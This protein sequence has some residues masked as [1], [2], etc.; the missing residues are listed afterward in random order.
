M[1][2]ITL[3]EESFNSDTN[4]FVIAGSLNVTLEHSLVSLSKWEALWKKPFL[5]KN[6]NT[7]EEILSYLECMVVGNVPDK[8]WIS[9]LTTE[10]VVKIKA[11]IEDDQ[12]ATTF[13]NKGSSQ[14]RVTETITSEL[15][16]YWMISQGI[17]FTC[18]TWHLQRLITLINVCLAKNQKPKKMSQADAA[19]RHHQ[20]NEANKL[21]YGTRG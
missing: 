16:Y 3:N 15:V 19:R 11:Y 13:P 9:F 4:E 12:T 17:P 10:D 21:K 14:S 20:I 18:E 2:V 6:Q 1:L 7:D 5:D 8:N